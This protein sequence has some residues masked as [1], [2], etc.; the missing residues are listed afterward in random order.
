MTNSNPQEALDAVRAYM[1][2]EDLHVPDPL[3]Q[4]VAL[5]LGYRTPIFLDTNLGA[6]DG[7]LTGTLVAYTDVNLVVVKVETIEDDVEI[8]ASVVSRKA[9]TGV[10]AASSVRARFPMPTPTPRWP[11]NA[12]IGLDYT[13]L[14]E[15]VT[16]P[17]GR[18]TRARNAVEQLLPSLL[19]DLN[20]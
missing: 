8:T 16:L 11:R 17:L 18:G 5:L 1:R 19:D 2:E 6:E 12:G 4:Q 13:G 7:P 15:S 10:R 3:V 20:S 9:L 14:G